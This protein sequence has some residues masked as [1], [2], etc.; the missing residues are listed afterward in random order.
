MLF[1]IF[2]EQPDAEVRAEIISIL[3]EL[4]PH[5]LNAGDLH[6]VAYLISETQVVLSRAEEMLPEHQEVLT[7]LTSTFSRPEA[8]EQHLD[9]LEVATIEASAD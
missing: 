3:S 9:A 1:D 8:V 6:S 7:G 5:L 4:L 2:E